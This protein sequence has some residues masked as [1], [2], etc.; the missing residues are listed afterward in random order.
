MSGVFEMILFVVIGGIGIVIVFMFGIFVLDL[1]YEIYN[2]I[3]G[4]FG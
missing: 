2:F 1:I 3:V 4:F